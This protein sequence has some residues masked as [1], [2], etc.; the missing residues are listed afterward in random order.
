MALVAS[1]LVL[2]AGSRGPVPL[3]LIAV[4]A[5][6]AGLAIGVW[7]TEAIGSEAL[8]SKAGSKV[9][10][11]G[12]L[13]EAPRT[14]ST[15]WKAAV[16]TGEG[17]VLVESGGP[18]PSAPGP[19]D[20]VEVVGQLRPAPPWLESG[21][22]AR[23]IELALGADRVRFTEARRGGATGLVDSIRG[24]AERA[25]GF[26][27]GAPEAALARG[28]VLG[29]DQAIDAGVRDR[30]RDSGLAHLL[31]VSGQN[32]MLLLILGW[33]LFAGLGLPLRLRYPL[34]GALVCLYVP[35]AGG[36]PSIQRAG[37]M[38]LAGLAAASAGRPLDR[39]FPVALA[40]ALTLG[41]NPYAAGDPGW[42]LSFAAVLGIVVLARPLADRIGLALG[43]DRNGFRAALAT[44]LAVTVA[45][46]LATL[47][48]IG[49]HFGRL[50]LGTVAAN[51]LALPAVAPSMW[52]GMVSATIGQLAPWLA[53]P[54]NLVN[55]VL[56][57]WI[58]GIAGLLGGPDQVLETGRGPLAF[59]TISAAA[60]VVAVLLVRRPGFAAF[61][62]AL[63]LILP[64]AGLV[65]GPSR[66]L[67]ELP[68]SGLA[69]DLL[70]VGQG[71]AI[72][73]RHQGGDPVLVDTG[74]PGGG[75]VEAVLGSGGERLGGLVLTHLD[76]DHVGE[77]DRVL[78]RFEVG[79]VMVDRI[80]R[81]MRDLAK[82][83]GSPVRKIGLGDG[84]RLG[85]AEVEVLW[86]PVT[87]SGG[88]AGDRNARSIV[89]MVRFAGR[90][91][92]LTGDAEAELV[93]LDPGRVDVLKVAHHGSEDE[94]LPDLLAS[95]MPA[96]SLV[97]SGAGNPYGH[98]VDSTLAALRGSGSE[99]YRTDRQ[100]TVSVLLWPSGR[101]E[102]ET[103]R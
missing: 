66:T 29:Q 65:S 43:G 3:A 69:I 67:P 4:S 53:L 47:P 2:L 70:D 77:F 31:A 100:G 82:S 1:V 86:P 72:L 6:V 11:S 63:S 93:P 44:G 7:R 64:L 12:F 33:V 99:T 88:A 76:R 34:L 21:L 48:L 41:L 22:R 81:E 62:I 61:A 50:P 20:G 54:F 91:I 98:P 59:L 19:G 14:T 94:G 97:S 103:A 75:V 40:A 37:V 60:S 30:F 13:L 87:A 9:T 52:L 90:S 10:L 96:L 28:F 92:L 35:L 80:T 42:Q 27:I 18:R 39:V 26:G 95:A 51:T 89:L 49:L 78:T 16:E 5:A 17:R 57:A 102:V 25:L 58:D 79:S 36:G 45:A 56:L 32:V 68:E 24:R 55:A 38:G 8:E 85:R 71:D 73:I 83:V 15:G 46:S 23:G 84:F 101:I 74:P